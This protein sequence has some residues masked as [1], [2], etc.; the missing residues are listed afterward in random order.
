MIV[1]QK[2]SDKYIESFDVK[3]KEDDIEYSFN[4]IFYMDD[5]K[6]INSNMKQMK[7]A[8][9]IIRKTQSNYIISTDEMIHSQN[10]LKY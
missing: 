6:V 1:F 9:S 2:T 3:N 5:L 4:H 7:Y 8:D 10:V